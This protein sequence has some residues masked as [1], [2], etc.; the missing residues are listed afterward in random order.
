MSPAAGRPPLRLQAPGLADAHPEGTAALPSPD[1]RPEGETM[2]AQRL[3]RI[4]RERWVPALVAALLVMAATGAA[5]VIPAPRYEASSSIFVRTAAGSISDRSVAADYARQQITTY[6]DLAGTPL[7]LDPAIASLGLDTTSPE[8]AREVE[9]TVP[10]DT[11]LIMITVRAEDA[12]GAAR[13]ADAVAESLRTQVA[14][15]EGTSSVELTIVTPA[16]MP[17]APASPDV[18]QNIVLG[19]LA[20]LLAAVTAAL[21]R[22]LLD[23]RVRTADDIGRLT[24]APLLAS[25]P[26]VR[27]RDALASVLERDAQGIQSEAYREL[28]TNLRFLELRGRS[29][30]LLV[31]SSIK[32]EGKTTT[33]INLAAALAR[34]ER[35]VLLV[36]AD[37]RDPSVH[38]CLGLEGGAGLSTVLIG[39]AELEDVLQPLDLAGLTVL[40]SGPVPPNPSELLDSEQMSEFLRAA[41]EQFDVVILDSAPLLP[42]TDATALARRVS[43]T[44]FVTGSGGVRRAQVVQAL[45]KLRI[46]QAR[47]L[48]IVLNRVP[49]SDRT[50]YADV[51]GAAATGRAVVREQQ[52]GDR[53]EAPSDAPRGPARSPG[54]WGREVLDHAGARGAVPVRPGR[55]APPSP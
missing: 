32:G 7:V 40:A 38:R 43:G 48:G 37:L 12:E 8:L 36:D 50:V 42:V 6:A 15:L 1:R 44:A 33:A 10:E 11:S 46:V 9:A 26:S 53:P 18:V 21:L 49:R 19:L 55:S 16:T 31:T 25:V 23:S 2:S 13:L 17:A 30:S 28:R 20:A 35:S 22:D 29:R 3:F 41:T 54:P 24:D 14:G 51:Y 5:T 45:L 52:G 47:V 27:S 34:S 4:L 39:D